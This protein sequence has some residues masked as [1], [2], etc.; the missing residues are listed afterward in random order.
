MSLTPITDAPVPFSGAPDPDYNHPPPDLIL[1]SGDGVDLHV[2]KSVLEYTSVFFNNMFDGAHDA[3]AARRNGKPIIDLPEP[4]SVLYRV[5]WIT[6]PPKQR[7]SLTV[8]DLDGVAAVYQAARKYLFT[9]VL[10][11]LEENLDQ[12][13]LMAAAPHRL[14]AI[15]RLCDLPGV[16][17]KAALVTLTLLVCPRKLSFP[18]LA[19]LPAAHLQKLYDFHYDCGI[20][21]G[22][23]IHRAA[24]PRDPSD[25]DD[26]NRCGPRDDT[27][28]EGRFDER[29]PAEWFRS[30]IARVASQL[31]L[32]PTGP[33]V[34][35]L[36]LE[37]FPAERAIIDSCPVC[38]ANATTD[39][40]DLARQLAKAIE[41]SNNDLDR[42]DL[43]FLILPDLCSVFSPHNIV[44]EFA[45]N[46]IIAH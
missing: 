1:R 19:L 28:D 39:L 33:T 8:H 10:E 30:H 27:F 25:L 44:R 43:G 6:Y 45:Y 17:R 5:L 37:I 31:T 4:G 9:D 36:A 2:K 20:Q 32:L 40:A 14:F 12:A 46:P 15:A 38:S 21:A 26:P 35:P 41:D 34:N 11:T 24:M 3:T 13:D 42:R 7:Y 29:F 22:T 18:E 23:I 16:A